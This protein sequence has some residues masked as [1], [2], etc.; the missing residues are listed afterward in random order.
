MLAEYRKFTLPGKAHLH[1]SVKVIPTG[2]VE[3]FIKEKHDELHADFDEL[4]FYSCGKNTELICKE[5][6]GQDKVRWHI[7]L[8]NEDARELAKLIESAEEE[9]EILMRDL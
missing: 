4:C 1:A 2:E 7:D 8:A 9:F 5:H 6:A 3:V